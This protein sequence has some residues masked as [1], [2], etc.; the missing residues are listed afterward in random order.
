MSPRWA[1][2]Q[3]EEMTVCV[4]GCLKSGGCV[5]LACFPGDAAQFA[6]CNAQIGKVAVAQCVQFVQ[7]LAVDAALG[8]A[9]GCGLQQ[10]ACG[11]HQTLCQRT[12]GVCVVIVSHMLSL[13]LSSARIIRV[14]AL[15]EFKI[16]KCCDCTMEHSAMPLCSICITLG[17]VCVRCAALRVHTAGPHCGLVL[18]RKKAN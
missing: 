13:F 3:R 12:V 1:D 15:L 7:R 5:H 4:S 8:A 6:T 11:C 16:G 17:K 18:W 14:F 2:G 10:G 9:Q